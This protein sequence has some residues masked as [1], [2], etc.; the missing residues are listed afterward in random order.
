MYFFFIYLFIHN[1]I[2]REGIF[3]KKYP[4]LVY[5]QPYKLI[6]Q[7]GTIGFSP[8]GRVSVAVTV[9]LK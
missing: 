3:Q 1:F 4:S 7:C 8:A 9:L 2:L 6:I 5:L